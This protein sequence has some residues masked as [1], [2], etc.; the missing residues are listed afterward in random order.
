[1]DRTLVCGEC[2]QSLE[3]NN[4]LAVVFHSI[5]CGKMEETYQGPV[6]KISQSG[7]FGCQLM[8]IMF[9]LKPFLIFILF[10]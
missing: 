9:C 4:A 2:S 5:L 1:M 8:L 3:D 10:W 6:K 7:G